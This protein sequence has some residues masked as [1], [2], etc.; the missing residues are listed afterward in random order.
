MTAADLALLYDYGPPAPSLLPWLARRAAEEDLLLVARAAAAQAAAAPMVRWPA[1]A[2]AVAEVLA[3]RAAGRPELISR[4]T[5]VLPQVAA[6]LSDA[7][8]TAWPG[9]STRAEALGYAALTRVDASLL[10]RARVR[11]TTAPWPEILAAARTRTVPPLA[12]LRLLGRLAAG[13]PVRSGDLAGLD[14][15]YLLPFL[16]AGYGGDLAEEALAEIVDFIPAEAG[17]YAAALSARAAPYLDQGQRTRLRDAAGAAPPAWGMVLRE[18]AGH[19]RAPWPSAAAEL[20]A[21]HPAMTRLTE[22]AERLGQAE[23]ASACAPVIGQILRSYGDPGSER[24]EP[25][26]FPAVKEPALAV[27]TPGSRPRTWGQELLAAGGDLAAPVRYL[28][29]DGPETVRTGSTFDF[30]IRIALA[31]SGVRSTVPLRIDVPPEGRDVLL[32]LTAPGLRILG[33]H[34]QNLHVPRDEDSAWVPFSLQADAPGTY[35]VSAVAVLEGAHLGT[36]AFNVTAGPDGPEGSIRRVRSE[37]GMEPVAG[38]VSLFARYERTE[39]KQGLYRFQLFADDNPSEVTQLLRIDPEDSIRHLIQVLDDL[40]QGRR[41]YREDR[42]RRFLANKGTELWQNLV[43]SLLH[44]QFWDHR[45]GI[46]QLTILTDNDVIPWEVLYPKDTGHDHGFLVEQ[47]PVTRNVFNRRPVRRLRLR[48]ARFVLPP[49]APTQAVGEVEALRELLGETS[50]DAVVTDLSD[51]LDLLDA[52]DFGMLHVACH[53]I[54]DPVAGSAIKFDGELFTPDLLTQYAADKTLEDSAPL[55]FVNGCRTGGLSVSYN[56]LEGWATRFMQAGAGAFIGSQWAVADETA[57]QFAL[58]FYRQ[59]L[60]GRSLGEAAMS[61]RKA[62]AENQTDPTWLAYSL[63]GDP[64]AT[65]S[66]PRR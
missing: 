1:V 25:T 14:A 30:R 51:L 55:V 24:W 33:E 48:P 28:V 32:V 22:L 6:H 63:Y 39:A 64:G 66:Q 7:D 9:T 13:P 38:A 45:A 19:Q 2:D 16:S 27:I 35:Q 37:V 20:A 4:L 61:A 56:K 42:T 53:N 34:C 58:H 43:P 31:P 5:E 10:D 54:F 49:R 60:E 59:L 36:L 40:A 18:L 46:S 41:R 44:E 47:F 50:D 57:P 26:G 15:A 52:G 65:I 62:I 12:N 23:L 8:L 3:E 29:G 11:L 17:W 21:A